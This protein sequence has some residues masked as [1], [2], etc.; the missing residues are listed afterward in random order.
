M[1]DAAVCALAASGAI[2]TATVKAATTIVV[3]LL[4]KVPPSC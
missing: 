3:G 2:N 4:F 1:E